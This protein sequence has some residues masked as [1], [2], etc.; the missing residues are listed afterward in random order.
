VAVSSIDVQT[1]AGHSSDGV[2]QMS[3]N[4][5]SKNVAHRPSVKE[6]SDGVDWPS[7]APVPLLSAWNCSLVSPEKAA[8]VHEVSRRENVTFCL[9]TVVN[10][11]GRTAETREL[12]A[13]R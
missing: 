6:I 5:G 10:S 3:S 11:A 9:P 12:S 8:P 7:R 2:A 13:T 4:V 1:R